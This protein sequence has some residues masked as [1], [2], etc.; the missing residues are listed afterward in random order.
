MEISSSLLVENGPSKDVHV[1]SPELY[2]VK[3]GA[4]GLI[5]LSALG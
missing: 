1:Q 3:K 5:K 2:M 4:E